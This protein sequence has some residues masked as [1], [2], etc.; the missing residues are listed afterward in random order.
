MDTS[1]STSFSL[2]RVTSFKS[3]SFHT[4]FFFPFKKKFIFW[5]CH[6]ACGNLVPWVGIEPSPPALEEQSPNHWTARE[7]LISP[8][9]SYKT[10]IDN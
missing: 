9:L 2:S 8:F 6:V 10:K 7:L 1:F 3:Y 5:P 4:A